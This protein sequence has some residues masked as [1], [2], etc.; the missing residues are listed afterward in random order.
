DPDY[1]KRLN[2]RGLV[3][4]DVK[5]RDES[6]A[7]YDRAVAIAPAYADAFNNRGNVLQELRCYAD[8]ILNFERALAIQP[9]HTWAFNGLADSARKLCDW[10]ITARL[11]DQLSAHVV[12]E[13]SIINPFTL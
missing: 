12:H 9:D 3:L 5:R 13:K 1:A 2:N 6:L 4:F 8:A 7:N 10:A 11:S